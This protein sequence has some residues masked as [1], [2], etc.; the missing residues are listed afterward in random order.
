MGSSLNL[1]MLGGWRRIRSVSGIDDFISK[2]FFCVDLRHVFRCFLHGLKEVFDVGT[3]CFVERRKEPDGLAQ[4]P[5]LL[6][7]EVE[8]FGED[9]LKFIPRVGFSR[10]IGEGCRVSPVRQ[11]G[12][13]GPRYAPDP[14][15]PDVGKIAVSYRERE[16]RDQEVVKK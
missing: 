2:Y 8:Y 7:V 1:K 6:V 5:G 4:H 11:Q 10:G 3:H 16:R 9:L 15:Y 12:I 14:L 13:N